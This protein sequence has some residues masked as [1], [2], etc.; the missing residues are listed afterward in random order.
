MKIKKIL[1]YAAPAIVGAIITIALLHVMNALAFPIIVFAL[2]FFMAGLAFPDVLDELTGFGHTLWL[3][4][5]FSAVGFAG[6]YL[7]F[8]G[9]A[10]D[11][12]TT[13]TWCGLAPCTPIGAVFAAFFLG[14][15][16]VLA[17][18]LLSGKKVDFFGD[19]QK[20]K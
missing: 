2:G 19:R 6:M 10:F 7:G 14:S 13:S 20:S 4:L 15:L 16:S 8:E 12:I 3:P 9:K 18:D 11:M 1:N 5:G 17:G